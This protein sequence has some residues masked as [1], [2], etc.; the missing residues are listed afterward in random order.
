MQR[1]NSNQLQQIL[2]YTVQQQTDEQT[3]ENA[4]QIIFN[5]NSS[6]A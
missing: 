2:F 1:T 3:N 5:A 6:S 4:T